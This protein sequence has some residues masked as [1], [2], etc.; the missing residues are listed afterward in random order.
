MCVVVM[1]RQSCAELTI[2]IK[3]IIIMQVSV[4]QHTCYQNSGIVKNLRDNY[5]DQSVYSQL[6]GYY[7]Q[8]EIKQLDKWHDS[9]KL[10]HSKASKCKIHIHLA[11]KGNNIFFD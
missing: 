8:Q 5:I 7:S 4:L 9:M 2:G 1:I 3:K 6:L 10:L 11:L